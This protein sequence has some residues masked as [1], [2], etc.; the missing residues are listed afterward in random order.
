MELGRRHPS[1]VPFLETRFDPFA[2]FPG[3]SEDA[4]GHKLDEIKIHSKSTLSLAA[5]LAIS[6]LEKN[7][8]QRCITG[9]FAVRNVALIH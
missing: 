1:V 9:I 7:L 8:R 4:S 5:L 2:E 6:F 3:F